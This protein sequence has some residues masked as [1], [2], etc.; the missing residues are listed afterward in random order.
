MIC[1]HHQLLHVKVEYPNGDTCP[2]CDA[3]QLANALS[4]TLK[5]ECE[6][7]NRLQKELDF[8]ETFIRNIDQVI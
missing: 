2:L 5:T 1:P 6:R 3:Y 4:A 7:A 8:A